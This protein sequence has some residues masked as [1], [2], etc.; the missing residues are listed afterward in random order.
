MRNTFQEGDRI[1]VSQFIYYFTTPKVGDVVV[2]ETE[3]TPAAKDNKPYFIERVVGLPGDT[4]EITP[5]GRLKRNGELLEKPD[6]FAHN[7]YYPSQSTHQTIF[8]V[9]KGKVFVFGDN[10]RNS[11]DSRVLGGIPLEDV[12]GKAIFRY[13]PP[14][15]IGFIRGEAPPELSSKIRYSP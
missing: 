10:S 2:F 4:I 13:W 9:P 6:I 5:E 1:L 15:R 14:N 12:T 11:F 3:N 8:K 7:R